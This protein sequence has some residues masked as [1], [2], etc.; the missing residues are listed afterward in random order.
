M[1]RGSAFPKAGKGGKGAPSGKNTIHGE[2]HSRI[3]ETCCMTLLTLFSKFEVIP[4]ELS[5]D[6]R[7]VTCQYTYISLGPSIKGQPVKTPEISKGARD[8]TDQDSIYPLCLL[9]FCLTAQQSALLQA[10]EELWLEELGHTNILA[11]TLS[12]PC[13]KNKISRRRLSLGWLQRSQDHIFV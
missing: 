9:H 12:P 8:D 11:E 4:T 7:K 6:S 3:F 1:T 5:T 2:C 10:R 13:F